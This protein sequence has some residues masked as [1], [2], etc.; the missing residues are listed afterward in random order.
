MLAFVGAPCVLHNQSTFIICHYLNITGRIIF[1]C[2]SP[3]NYFAFTLTEHC[4]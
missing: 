3:E 2:L 4:T 1:I